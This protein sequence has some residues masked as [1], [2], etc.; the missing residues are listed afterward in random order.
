MS[1]KA[2]ESFRS[3]LFVNA[4]TR[5]VQRLFP[6][7]MQIQVYAVYISHDLSYALTILCGLSRFDQRCRIETHLFYDSDCKRPLCFTFFASADTMAS[8]LVVIDASARRAT[9]KT[10]P[11]K[12]LS[13]VLQEACS[14]L[15]ADASRYGLK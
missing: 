5:L 6:R 4:C 11:A 7:W 14:K 12:V 10:T 9:I 3:P 15:G 13:D 1:A 8:N 2:E